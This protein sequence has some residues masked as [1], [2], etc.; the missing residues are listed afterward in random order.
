MM[1]ASVM[2]LEPGIV[3]V[4]IQGKEENPKGAQDLTS[5]TSFF[6]EKS[7]GLEQREDRRTL[8][9]TPVTPAM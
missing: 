9:A 3:I 8:R 2:E 7:N 1:K 6:Y 5:I 4:S